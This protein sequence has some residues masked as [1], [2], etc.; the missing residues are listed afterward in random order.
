MTDPQVEHAAEAFVAVL[1]EWRRSRGLS[2]KQ[3]AADMGFDPSYVSHVEAGRHRPTEDFARRAEARARRRRGGVAP[4]PRV[5]RGPPA[6]AGVRTI[7]RPR[8]DP[9]AGEPRPP[10]VVGTV[11]EHEE[12]SLR[13]DGDAYRCVIRRRLY[14]AGREPVTRYLVRIAVDRYPSEPERSNRHYRDHPLT[15]AELDLTADCARRTDELAVQARPGRVQGGLAALRERR[16]AVPALPGPADHHRVR[17]HGRYRQVGPMVPA[18]RA[19][20]H[21]QAVGPARLPGQPATGRVGGRDLVDRRGRRPEVA[22]A[23]AAAGRPGPV[24]VVH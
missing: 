20:A 23:G 10:S 22:R 11:V 17:L 2:K 3:L 12:A 5:R 6:R 8:A 9:T 4:V 7:P 24:H 13:H 15:W 14:N 21:R 19:A 18:G 16:G 1:I